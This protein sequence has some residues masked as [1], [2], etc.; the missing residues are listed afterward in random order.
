MKTK[1]QQCSKCGEEVIFDIG[2]KQAHKG[3][4]H[5]HHTKRTTSRCRTCGTKE[6]VNRKT[7]KK[8]IAGKNKLSKEEK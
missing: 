7:G 2:K 6:I 5:S 4:S 8:T 1:E 3:K